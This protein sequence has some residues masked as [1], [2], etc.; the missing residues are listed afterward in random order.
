MKTVAY[1][2]IGGNLGQPSR[3]LAEAARALDAQ[4]EI[5]VCR[6]SKVYR[7]PAVGG[8]HNQP[9][10]LNAVL[11]LETSLAPRALL[12]LFLDVEQSYG[13][14]RS[15]KWGPRTLDLDLLIF[16]SEE[17]DEPGLTL[18]HPRLHERAFVLQP[19]CDLNPDLIHP[20]IG[21][22]VKCLVDGVD[23]SQLQLVPNL[24]LVAS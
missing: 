7:N 20:T 24:V 5:E 10:Y 23:A 16:G 3:T 6:A 2:G 18:P 15:E 4:S 13:R 22:P 19:L 9:D 8:P 11:E 1:S 12:E 21:L 14:V 17:V